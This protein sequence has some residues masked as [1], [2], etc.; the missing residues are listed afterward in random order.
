M[1]KIKFSQ[2]LTSVFCF[3]CLLGTVSV[4]ALTRVASTGAFEEVPVPQV[5]QPVEE[6]LLAE[7]IATQSI[8]DQ[9]SLGSEVSEITE[10]ANPVEEDSITTQNVA[11]V[12][13]GLYKP[14][15]T[16]TTVDGY[17]PV[18]YLG[19][20]QD[21]LRTRPAQK[22]AVM[23]AFQG[24]V[25]NVVRTGE[26]GVG[27]LLGGRDGYHSVVASGIDGIAATGYYLSNAPGVYEVSAPPASTLGLVP[28][29]D[30]QVVYELLGRPQQGG[31]TE[32]AIIPEGLLT[33]NS[34]KE[35]VLY[36]DADGFLR[37]RLIIPS[38][39]VARAFA[40]A[41]V[42]FLR[43]GEILAA[44]T[45]DQMGVYEIPAGPVGNGF[46]SIVVTGSQGYAV[47]A[48]EIADAPLV[49]A[50]DPAAPAPPTA[51]D[52]AAPP[53]IPAAQEKVSLDNPSDFQQV[54]FAENPAVSYM[55]PASNDTL[56]QLLESIQEI[57]QFLAMQEQGNGGGAGG[58][59][60]PYG[61]GGGGAG[62]GGSGLGLLGLAGLAGL[63][64]LDD[65]NNNNVV[66]P[67]AP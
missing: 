41:S 40:G 20:D 3:V 35:P 39:D 38:K 54:F 43:N 36:A 45:T 23:L 34:S 65:D 48:T 61:S 2:H 56:P 8:V 1:S 33:A 30:T 57:Q 42:T 51:T 11:D 46:V 60:S 9:Q 19:I 12:P 16:P 25:A 67:P 26:G 58:G 44:A 31:G 4:G 27:Q 29:S 5:T 66:S 37:S 10:E 13:V 15:Y 47:Y 53:A 21:Y 52:S 14:W 50:A 22:T 6:N 59:G 17:I 63:A 28:L 49:N 32:G 64:A 18:R 7:N 55:I 24:N 62:G